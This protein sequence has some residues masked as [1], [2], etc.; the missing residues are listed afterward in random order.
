V[1][2]RADR[3]GEY[4]N[5]NGIVYADTFTASV[6]EVIA[7]ELNSRRCSYMMGFIDYQSLEERGAKFRQS[8]RLEQRLIG[9]Y[10]PGYL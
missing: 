4:W 5:R 2:K 3:D 8:L 7:H 10:C 1:A 6:I 9:C